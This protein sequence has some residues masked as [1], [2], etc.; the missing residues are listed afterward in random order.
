MASGRRDGRR[1]ALL[2]VGILRHTGSD[3]SIETNPTFGS[4]SDRNQVM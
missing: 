4:S 3:R 1:F 2:F